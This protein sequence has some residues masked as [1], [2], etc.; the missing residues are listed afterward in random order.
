MGPLPHSCGNKVR[1]EIRKAIFF[2]HTLAAGA[3]PPL[4]CPL[5]SVRSDWPRLLWSS[6]CFASDRSASHGVL[7]LSRSRRRRSQPLSRT[8]GLRFQVRAAWRRAPHRTRTTNCE[9]RDR[10]ARCAR[11]APHRGRR[12][13]QGGHSRRLDRVLQGV[14]QRRR[15][16]PCRLQAVDFGRVPACRQRRW[17]ATG[18]LPEAHPGAHAQADDIAL[19]PARRCTL[20]GESERDGAVRGAVHG[21]ARYGAW[22]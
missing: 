20:S 21:R 3:R 14:R 13:I 1:M 16:L 17:R 7:V 18:R 8:S 6:T 19:R 9:L 11:R 5:G 2:A 15:H 10:S 22:T 4:C 12:P